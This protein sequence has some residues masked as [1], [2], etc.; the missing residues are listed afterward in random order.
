VRH[1][2]W[3][4][5]ISALYEC[6]A[7]GDLCNIVGGFNWRSFLLKS[8]YVL[9]GNTYSIICW[10]VT[11]IS[12]LLFIM[13]VFH[14]PSYI[15]FTLC[16]EIKLVNPHHK[17]AKLMTCVLLITDMQKTNLD[18]NWEI[19]RQCV[20]VMRCIIYSLSCNR[21]LTFQ[22]TIV[23]KSNMWHVIRTVYYLDNTW[24]IFVNNMIFFS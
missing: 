11:K 18:T 9:H 7:V 5:W 13:N 10:T 2:C 21:N 1:K 6:Y 22:E 8:C 19:D 24:N 4:V 14:F 20:L 17:W 23:A 12:V 3:A 16:P 15:Y